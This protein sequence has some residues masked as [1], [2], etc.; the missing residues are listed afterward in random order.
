MLSGFSL[1]IGISRA[2]NYVRERRRAAPRLRGLA[3]MIFHPPGRHDVRVH[4][5]VPGIGIAFV[6][7]AASILTREDG[8]EAWLS[9]PFGVGLGLTVDELA[10][11]LR[12]DDHYWKSAK[13]SLIKAGVAALGSAGLTARFYFGGRDGAI[14]NGGPPDRDVSNENDPASTESLS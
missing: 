7:G 1:T 14:D 4:H 5:F 13:A 12:L 11:L 10:Q 6:T 8:A 9:F 2:I 3:R